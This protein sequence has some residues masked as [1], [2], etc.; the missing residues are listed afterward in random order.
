[1]VMSKRHQAHMIVKRTDCHSWTSSPPYQLYPPSEVFDQDTE[2]TDEL[3]TELHPS[4]SRM[5]LSAPPVLEVAATVWDRTRKLTDGV[6]PPSAFY[7][8][9][10]VKSSTGVTMGMLLDAVSRMFEED[11]AL[12][13]IKVCTI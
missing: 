1:M 5:Q 2:N 10:R 9:K 13:E 4:W 12:N 3:A 8:T 6:M 7:L 11:E